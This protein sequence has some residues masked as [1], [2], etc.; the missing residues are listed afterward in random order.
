MLFRLSLS[1]LVALS[2]MSCTSGTGGIFAS[3][4]KEQKIVDTGNLSNSATFTHMT[5]FSGKYYAAG[6]RSLYTRT[7]GSSTEWTKTNTFLGT[8]YESVGAVGSTSSRLYA[9]V[10][11]KGT[12]NNRLLTSSDGATWTDVTPSGIVPAALVPVRKTDG[13]S[14]DELVMSATDYKTVYL[15]SGST[16]PAAANLTASGNEITAAVTVGTSY[17]L[18]N[19]SRFFYLATW[20]T[21]AVEVNSPATDKG[22]RGLIAFGAGATGNS[23]FDGKAFLSTNNGD[24]YQGTLSAGVWTAG[25][26]PAVD[27]TTNSEKIAFGQ[28]LFQATSGNQALWI[29]VDHAVSYEGYGYAALSTTGALSLLPPSGTDSSNFSSS[30]LDTYAVPLLFKGSDGYFLGTWGHGLWLWNSTTQ[31]WSQQ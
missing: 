17:Y 11:N 31:T 27:K 22:M 19:E 1:L 8:T 29:G 24:V 7:V 6:G 21:P 12:A 9:L 15:L 28:M 2:F 25:S 14:S 30:K 5:E 20:S 16:A 13:I 26:N 4:E 10:N 18:V 3:L 23:T